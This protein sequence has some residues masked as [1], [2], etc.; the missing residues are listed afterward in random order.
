MTHVTIANDADLPAVVALVNSG[1]RGDSSRLGWTTE[2]DY[3]DG[4]RTDLATL[5]LD[6][7]AHP[8]A[9]LLLLRAE[10]GD[11]LLG[12]VWLEPKD[13]ESWYLGMLTVRPD[14]QDSGLGRTLLGEA[15]AFAAARGARR[16]KLSVF[17]IRDTLIAW[18]ERR[19][20]RRT[21]EE[22]PFPYGDARF[23]EALR[24]D[25]VFIAMEKT[26]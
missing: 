25:L 22:L 14:L 16:M 19:G 5:R 10:P 11:E 4:Q 17:S 3:L 12:S 9:V 24:D 1:Y 20:Y 26:L 23:G 8:G 6:L 15:E 13:A 7:A 21:G 2:A 18:Y